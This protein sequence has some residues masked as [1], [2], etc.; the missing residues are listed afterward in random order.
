MVV[1]QGLA[2]SNGVLKETGTSSHARFCQEMIVYHLLPC[3]FTQYLQ[4]RDCQ[5]FSALLKWDYVS[6]VSLGIVCS[7]YNPSVKQCI[8]RFQVTSTIKSNDAG[9]CARDHLFGLHSDGT[10]YA[11][12]PGTNY[13][14]NHL[15]LKTNNSPRVPRRYLLSRRE[16]TACL[17]KQRVSTEFPG[18]IT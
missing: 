17:S 11:V 9:S 1:L 8:R 4:T 13:Y 6:S 10:M 18:I 7:L 12:V 5:L 3:Q 14:L 16:N 2:E 15:P